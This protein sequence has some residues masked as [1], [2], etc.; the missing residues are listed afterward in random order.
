MTSSTGAELWQRFLEAQKN[1][2]GDCSSSPA[3]QCPWT[4]DTFVDITDFSD[5]VKSEKH[6]AHVLLWCPARDTDQMV[7]NYPLKYRIPVSFAL[8]GEIL[9]FMEVV[10]DYKVVLIICSPCT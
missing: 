5:M 2:D 8:F 3:Y 9:S 4:K 10:V 1:G 7:D 6:A